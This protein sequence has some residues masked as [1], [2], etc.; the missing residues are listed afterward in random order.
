ML[1]V[2]YSCIKAEGIIP[3]KTEIQGSAVG[4]QGQKHLYYDII[5]VAQVE[6]CNRIWFTRVTFQSSDLSEVND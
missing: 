4:D 5:L 3:I 6:H 1:G 2:C